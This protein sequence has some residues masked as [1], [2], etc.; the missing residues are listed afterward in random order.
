MDQAN[1]AGPASRPRSEDWWERWSLYHLEMFGLK[2]SQPAKEMLSLWRRIFVPEFN[3]AQMR[4]ATDHVARTNPPKFLGDHLRALR[5]A[6]TD[7]KRVATERRAKAHRAEEERG[8]CV[9]CF[10][11]GLVLVPHL[12][13]FDKECKWRHPLYGTRVTMAVSCHCY[14]GRRYR[15]PGTK[16]LTIEQYEDVVPDWAVIM[17]EAHARDRAERAVDQDTR[18]HGAFSLMIDNIVRRHA[19]GA[20]DAYEGQPGPAG[21]VRGREPG[22][23]EEVPGGPGLDPEGDAEPVGGE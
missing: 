4:A 22:D 13:S 5:T 17:R 23:E 11:S 7:L 10:N 21:P 12:R 3:E 6:I 16:V 9:A 8:T 18:S 20:G 2:A 15:Q 1:P 14:A 19:A